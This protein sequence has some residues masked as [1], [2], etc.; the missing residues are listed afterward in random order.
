MALT[1]TM[2]FYHL[3][4]HPAH[5]NKI[6][7][8][9]KTVRSIQE[10]TELQSLDH[11]NAVITETLR[12]YPGVPAGAPRNTPPEGLDIAGHHIPGNVSVIAPCYSLGRRKKIPKNNSEV[13]K[14]EDVTVES[15]FEKADHFIPERWYLKPEMVKDQ[16]ANKPFLLGTPPILPKSAYGTC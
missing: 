1:L 3:A 7:D 15:C 16:K 8:E 9:L 12:L 6:R 2:I 13:K 14:T 4:K 5:A 11:L 10:T